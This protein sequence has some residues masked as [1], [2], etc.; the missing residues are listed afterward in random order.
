M[1]PTPYLTGWH[2]GSAGGGTFGLRFGRFRALVPR[3]TKVI[4]LALAEGPKFEAKITDGFWDKCPEI[5][6]PEIRTW[7]AMQSISYPW[8]GGKPPKFKFSHRG[9]YFTVALATASL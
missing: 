3:N 5:R 1:N 8:P 6:A 4:T 2:S 7:M 9:E